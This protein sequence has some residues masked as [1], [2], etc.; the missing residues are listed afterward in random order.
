M[1]KLK[2]SIHSPKI[3][4]SITIS[5]DANGQLDL[6]DATTVSLTPGQ[7]HYLLKRLPYNISTNAKEQFMDFIGTTQLSVTQIVQEVNFDTFWEAYGKKVNRLRCEPLFAKLTA[8]DLFGIMDNIAQ[9]HAYLKRTTYRAIADP[10]TY[11]RKKMYK[12][13]WNE[14]DT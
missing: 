2:F 9:Y 13:N 6:I 1:H 3:G 5:Y 14:L 10:E 8:V 7:F 11:L 4:G 12:T